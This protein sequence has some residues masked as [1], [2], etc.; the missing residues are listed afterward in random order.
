MYYKD[1]SHKKS[2]VEYAVDCA[3]EHLPID[4]AV[5]FVASDSSTVTET[6]VK[7]AAKQ[8]RPSNAAVVVVASSSTHPLHLDRGS[9]FLATTTDSNWRAYPASAYYDIFVDLYLL[10]GARCVVHNNVGGYGRWASRIASHG[11]VINL[12][13]VECN[14]DQKTEIAAA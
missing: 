2:R 3:L 4:N 9:D 5:L 14:N 13:D 6:A 12:Q 1:K 10:S 7:Y 8:H 11:C